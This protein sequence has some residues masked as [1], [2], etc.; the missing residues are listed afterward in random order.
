MDE[1]NLFSLICFLALVEEDGGLFTKHPYYLHT[2]K[3]ILSEGLGAYYSLSE[4][5]RKLLRKYYS[6]W[7]LSWPL[8]DE[9]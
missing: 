5:A 4:H 6:T 3:S 2:K 8:P 1:K 7:G 9:K